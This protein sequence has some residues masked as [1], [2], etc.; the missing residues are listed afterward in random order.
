MRKRW[1]P[2]LW[3]A[4]CTT[5][6]AGHV[7]AQ[8]PDFDAQW[9]QACVE[10]VR[11]VAKSTFSAKAVGSVEDVG[12]LTI[13]EYDGNYARGL[14]APRQEIADRFYANHPDAYDFLVVFSTFEFETG[15]AIAFHNRIRNDTSGIGLPPYDHSEAFGIAGRLQRLACAS[16]T[17][18]APTVAT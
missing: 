11:P 13:I 7:L 15:T 17:P 5:A 9:P 1:I 18:T 16:S 12:N 10:E 6:V 4:C 2:V 14:T 3:M 8:S